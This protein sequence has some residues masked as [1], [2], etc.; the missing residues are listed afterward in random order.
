M[1]STV[2]RPC[3]LALAISSISPLML[4][5]AA[6]PASQAAAV[7]YDIAAA[8]LADVLSQIAVVSGQNI[9]AEPKL[10]EGKRGST[11][12]GNYTP[13]QAIEQALVGTGL[14]A[15][16]N[17]A[18]G[19]VIRA[20]AQ[21]NS[22]VQENALPEVAVKST[23][24]TDGT[25]EGTRSYTT[26]TMS[27]AT[28][29]PLSLRE[30]PQ[31]VTVITRQRMDDQGMLNITD[32]VKSTPGIFLSGSDGQGRPLFMARGFGISTVMH[33]GALMPWSSY[34]PNSQSNLAMY[35]RVEIVRGSTGLT[36]GAGNP[37][38]AVNMVRKR[39][40]KEFQGSVTAYAGSWDNYGSIFDV[41]GS[42]NETGSMR[43]RVVASMQDS[44]SFREGQ[45]YDNRLFYAV[46]EADLSE[47]TT[48]T[49]G[50]SAQ[51]DKT[52]GAWWGG[53][54]VDQSGRHFNL[55]RSTSLA[56]SWEYLDQ[57]TNSVFGIMEHQFSEDWKLKFNV[58]NLW[59]NI[60]GLGSYMWAD[61]S[62]TPV[63]RQFMTWRG[64]QSNKA[65]SY[66]LV[67][68]G[69][70]DAFGRKHE[71][72]IGAN[73]N[74]YDSSTRNYDYP[75]VG[76]FVDIYN[77]TR[78][79]LAK[80]TLT[81]SGTSHIRTRQDAVY[82]TGRFNLADQ[83][84]VIL[85]ARLDWYHYDDFRNETEDY[86]ITHNVTRYAGVIYDINDQHSFYASFT[87]IFLPQSERARNGSILQPRDGKNYEIG[88]KG[89]YFEGALNASV[90]L[91]QIDENNRPRLVADVSQCQ[92]G[93]SCYEAAGKVRSRGVDMELQGAIRP[94][95]QV[96]AG[97]TYT[98]TEYIKD[99]VYA[100]GDRVDT[101]L[102]EHMFK[103]TTMYHFLGDLDQWRLGA[104]LYQQGRMYKLA[105]EA[106]SDANIEQ[107]AY[108]VL[109]L[110]VGYKVNQKLDLQLNINNLLDKHYYR[111]I[112]NGVEWGPTDV[113]GEP[114]SARITARYT[115]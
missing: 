24:L 54:P 91:F 4:A 11:V 31:S 3:L 111:S 18:G 27:T 86:K 108:A 41:G 98:N 109:D 37:S 53:L 46:G 67:L 10:V 35:D 9:V 105:A 16:A 33:D 78:S 38:A 29:L 55:K 7:Q 87:D 22:A 21:L 45:S 93:T 92:V 34:I 80:P 58:T 83:L 36:Q 44:G 96:G 62:S 32:A 17:E 73:R 71:L 12:R 6:E 82:A 88:L 14:Q 79:S 26:Q 1:Q 106:G 40:T 115:F 97:Y 110:I 61:T 90:A 70:V 102:P 47:K 23:V 52:N 75:D 72:V 56:S 66:D 74:Q 99:E 48:L 112:A 42:L 94:N 103:L 13:R 95:W 28:R 89:E 51:K 19:F 2:F 84:K 76:S 104:N 60:D 8:G 49:V 101:R 68:N 57:E 114:R 63:N 85:G 77:W 59:A 50:F 20:S 65:S 100:K 69:S 43:G 64:E 25:T 30:T 5:F 39:P 113:Y 107:K 15:I 81:Y